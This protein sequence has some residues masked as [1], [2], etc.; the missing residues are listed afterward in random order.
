MKNQAESKRS[1]SDIME[2]L[3]LEDFPQQYMEK[4]WTEIYKGVMTAICR[5][6][7][8]ELVSKLNQFY[9]NKV[10]NDCRY[11][12]DETRNFSVQICKYLNEV[13]HPDI[14]F[15]IE[16]CL[17]YFEED[18]PQFLAIIYEICRK[19]NFILK[20]ICSNYL[21]YSGRKDREVLLENIF[22]HLQTLRSENSELIQILEDI[23]DI[24]RKH[25]LTCYELAKNGQTFC[26]SCAPM[27]LKIKK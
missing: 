26:E 4:Y 20:E 22:Q 7:N 9:L 8:V 2:Q 5:F 16:Y 17:E 25:I 13:N 12:R 19:T 11:E 27:C 1:L 14:E 18:F 10:K 21:R 15:Y 6:N 24:E 3:R 23:K